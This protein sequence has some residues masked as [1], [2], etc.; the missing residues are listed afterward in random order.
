DLDLYA[1]YTG[2]GLVN[3]LKDDVMQDPQKTY[4]HV[5][6]R[7]N[8]QWDLAWLKPFG[9]NNSYTLTMRREQAEKLGIETISDLAEYVRGQRQG[10]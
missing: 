6:E 1:E 4:D 7:F 2:T 5:K 8:E 3:I 10:D 9:F